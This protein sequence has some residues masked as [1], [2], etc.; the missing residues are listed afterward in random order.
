[1][2][3]QSH[4]FQDKILKILASFFIVSFFVCSAFS[5]ENDKKEKLDRVQTTYGEAN[6]RDAQ[7]NETN[8]DIEKI[9]KTIFNRTRYFLIPAR[10]V[11]KPI[12]KYFGAPPLIIDMIDNVINYT[13]IAGGTLSTVEAF[14]KGNYVDCGINA[15]MTASSFS[16]DSTGTKRKNISEDNDDEFINKKQKTDTNPEYIIKLNKTETETG[17][18]STGGLGLISYL[19]MGCI[20][21]NHQSTNRKIETNI[22]ITAYSSDPKMP[23]LEDVDLQPKLLVDHLQKA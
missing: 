8:F 14:N 1:M 11:A 3:N 2:N 21:F 22:E 23:S 17:P 19:S 15:I 7:E 5:L 10:I 20:G 4:Y 18:Q 9:T 12:L 13:T 16:L 6:K